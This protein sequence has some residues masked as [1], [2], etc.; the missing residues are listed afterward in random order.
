MTAVEGGVDGE[1]APLGPLPPKERPRIVTAHTDKRRDIE[2]R[3][4]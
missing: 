2:R 1:P 4:S 3:C